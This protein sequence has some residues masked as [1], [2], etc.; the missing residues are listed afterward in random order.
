MN[1]G[2]NTHVPAAIRLVD[3]YA[4]GRDARHCTFV[5]I[6][7][8][9]A[10]RDAQ[11][12]QF[13]MLNVPGAG[14]SA[15]TFSALPDAQGRF[16]A[17]VR[18]VGSVTTALFAQPPG[19]VLGARGPFGT[20]WPVNHL[21]GKRVLVVGG[22]CGLAP[23]VSVV[24][25]IHARSGARAAKNLAV[26][27]SARDESAQVLHA[28]REQWRRDGIPLLEVFDAPH[29]IGPVPHLD[30][31]IAAL[32]DQPDI[33]LT[34]GPEAM[35]FA[36]ARALAQ[37]GVRDTDVFLSLERRMH[38]GTG[39]CGHCYIGSAYCCTDGPVLPWSA[40]RALVSLAHA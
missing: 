12:G 9:Q 18:R 3:S 38:C 37:R 26:L 28:E 17:L 1:T 4:D 34:C 33:V 27:Y 2:M 30:A 15:F 5:Y 16:S 10:P 24:R 14:E 11:P 29:C 31:A 40:A 23:L 36:L 25:D 7:P 35:M 20:G 6:D 39:H 32:G 19:A 8:A 13:F 22:G 21:A